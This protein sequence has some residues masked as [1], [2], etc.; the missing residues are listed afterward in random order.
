MARSNP[1]DASGVDEGAPCK[2]RWFGRGI[3]GAARAMYGDGPHSSLLP[4]VE[5][6][7]LSVRPRPPLTAEV[8]GVL[9][10][11]FLPVCGAIVIVKREDRPYRAHRHTCTAINTLNRIDVQLSVF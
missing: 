5:C 6:M 2:F 8:A 4:A 7:S 3:K 1:Y 9:L 10:R 11:V